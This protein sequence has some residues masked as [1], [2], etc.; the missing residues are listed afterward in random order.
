MSIDLTELERLLADKKVYNAWQYVTSLCENIGYMNMSYN[1]LKSVFEHRKSTYEEIGNE[2][3]QEAFAHPGEA[4]SLTTEHIKRTNLDIAGYIVDDVAF[5][6]K[7]TVEFFHYARISIDLLIQIT[8]AALFGDDA[9]DVMDM[10]L[11]RKVTSELSSNYAHLYSLFDG[12]FND[13]NYKYLS[14]FD[15][16]LKHIKTVLVKVAN[17]IIIGNKN[18]FIIDTFVYKN[19]RYPAYDAL[20]QVESIRSS[21]LSWID[22]VLS[23]VYSQIPNGKSTSKRIQSIHF[24]QFAKKDEN[25]NVVESITFFIDVETD[26][27]EL[28]SEISVYPLIKKPNGDI[29]S[30]DFKFEEIFIRRK[31]DK[32]I[33]GIAKIKNG[34]D[35]NEFYRIYTV[36]SC[37]E[38]A[39]FQYLISFKF[40]YPKIS[41]NYHAIDGSIVFC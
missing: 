7:T 12:I 41:L 27:S 19:T 22:T 11:I 33:I 9:F 35:T 4:A 15:N 2:I 29:Y 6:R 28:P 20:T 40:K 25:S 37:D 36:S 8:N 30:F 13:Q 1:L 32:K 24:E 23:E 10:G 26:L 31:N 38:K 18:D 21:V 3:M 16:Y 17:S 34:F 5:L 14:A 39:Y